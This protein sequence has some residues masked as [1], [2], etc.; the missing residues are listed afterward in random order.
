[1][2]IMFWLHLM[3]CPDHVLT[4]RECRSERLLCHE[5]LC[6]QLAKEKKFTTAVMER[7][8]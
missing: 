8:K 3:I 1:M 6:Y 5:E 4:N 2:T 7:I